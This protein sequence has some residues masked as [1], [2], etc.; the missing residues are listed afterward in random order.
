MLD[1]LGFET[2]QGQ[3]T[4]LFSEISGWVRGPIQHPLTLVLGFLPGGKV[5]GSWR[6]SLASI[7]WPRKPFPFVILECTLL[8]ILAQTNYVTLLIFLNVGAPT[9]LSERVTLVIVGL[10]A[11]R[12]WKN[13]L[14]Y[15]EMFIAYALFTNLAADLLVAGWRP[16]V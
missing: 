6:W 14:N 11:G 10:F 12:M 1:G 13:S 15:C 3:E 4:L 8:Y 5:A 16:L 9:F 7:A 2:R